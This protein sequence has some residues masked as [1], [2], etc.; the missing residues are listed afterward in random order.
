[1]DRY[2]SSLDRLIKLGHQLGVERVSREITISQISIEEYVQTLTQEEQ[3]RRH[4][5]S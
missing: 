2:L 4:P 3:T 1:V 5:S